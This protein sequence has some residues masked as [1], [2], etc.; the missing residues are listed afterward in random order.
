MSGLSGIP[1]D[2]IH[3]NEFTRGEGDILDVVPAAAGA[4]EIDL[5]GCF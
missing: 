4:P 3:V 2:M 5:S 1:E